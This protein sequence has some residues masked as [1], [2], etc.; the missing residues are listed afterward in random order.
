[1]YTQWHQDIH[2]S[3]FTIDTNYHIFYYLFQL[4]HIHIQ[5][6]PSLGPVRLGWNKT[7]NYSRLPIVIL[8]IIQLF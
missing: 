3:S 8:Q 2:G 5:L 1:M 4:S 7:R 6:G